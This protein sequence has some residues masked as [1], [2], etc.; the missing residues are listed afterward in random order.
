MA[1]PEDWTDVGQRFFCRDKLDE[2]IQELVLVF[3]N[4]QFEDTGKVLRPAGGAA[5]TSDVGRNRLAA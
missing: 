4:S 2:R 1:R 5:H 3:S